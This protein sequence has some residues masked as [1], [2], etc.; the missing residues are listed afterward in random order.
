MHS[1]SH[2]SHP[3]RAEQQA[4]ALLG[5]DHP[6][7]LVSHRLDTLAEQSLVV[8]GTLSASI[9][10]LVVGVAGAL[11]L[12]VAS[13]LAQAAFAGAIALVVERKRELALDLIIQGSGN[14][15]LVAIERERRRLLGHDHRQR[16]AQWL[17]AVCRDAEHPIQRPAFARPMCSAR[18]IAAV[19][20]DLAE[21]AR[22][23]R[24]DAPG[25]RGVAETQ[26]LLRDGTSALYG[27]EV[28]L[29]RQELHR[30]RFLAAGS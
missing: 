17:E 4:D 14:L 29:L 16:L 11:W 24:S 6:L 26:R 25:L 23:L 1:T 21:I 13:A 15:P 2:P 30:I 18:I 7:A 28:D 22:L 9:V 19:A 5:T 12:V 27:Q 8:A 3:L 20:A 10:L